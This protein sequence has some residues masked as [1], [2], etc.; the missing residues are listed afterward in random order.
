MTKKNNWL[1]I[2]AL[3]MV[4]VFGMAVIGCD[5]KNGNGDSNGNGGN[6]G[7]GDNAVNGSIS[8]SLIT[9]QN[10]S[11]YDSKYYYTIG[12]PLKITGSSW[13]S[14][15]GVTAKSW[16]N[17]TTTLDLTGWAFQVDYSVIMPDTLTLWYNSP[18]QDLAISMPIGGISVS[19]EQTELTEM[20]GY[21][22]VT[23]NF[24][25]G[26]PSSASSPAWSN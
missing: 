14:D 13:K 19:I 8:V 15:P 9:R 5:E 3:V 2:L 23:G 20:K 24:T 6:S 21:T 7:N 1:G 4:L 25:L 10:F 17:V 26:T 12:I 18:A 11:S 16:A 22:N